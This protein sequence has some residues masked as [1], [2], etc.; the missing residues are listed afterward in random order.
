MELDWYMDYWVGTTKHI[1]YAVDTV[2]QNGNKATINL[3]RVGLMP[4]PVDVFVKFTNG[5][6]RGY[7]IP[8][9]M[10]FQAKNDESLAPQTPWRWTHPTYTLEVEGP[11]PVEAVVIDNYG[12]MAD[13][14]QGNNAWKK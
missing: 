13:I 5:E 4:M 10:M 6:V 14:N 9:A 2:I 11:A 7:T 8:L 3:Q 1:D 12:F